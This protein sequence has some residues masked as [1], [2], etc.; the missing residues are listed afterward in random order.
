MCASVGEEMK[1][2]QIDDYF[3]VWNFVREILIFHPISRHVID[4][5][6]CY[7]LRPILSA[8]MLHAFKRILVYRYV[9]I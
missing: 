7:F 6:S 4:S 2:K 1:M 5:L 3:H 8:E 9:H